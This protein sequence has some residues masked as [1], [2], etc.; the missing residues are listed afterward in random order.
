MKKYR[1]KVEFDVV[2]DGEI[3]LLGIQKAQEFWSKE[4]ADDELTN[5]K[6]TIEELGGNDGENMQG[7]QQR[8]RPGW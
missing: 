4:F 1:F 7:I 8:R 6:C 2:D 5:V 3:E